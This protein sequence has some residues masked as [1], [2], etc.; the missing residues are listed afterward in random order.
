MAATV[1]HLALSRAVSVAHG[2]SHRLHRSSQCH[3]PRACLCQTECRMVLPLA[4]LMFLAKFLSPCLG[5]SH[6]VWGC[7]ACRLL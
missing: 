3:L 1:V 2:W 7:K 6:M 4:L 5:K